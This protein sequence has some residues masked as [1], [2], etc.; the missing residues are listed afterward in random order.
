MAG[1]PEWFGDS[2]KNT[3]SQFVLI[4]EIVIGATIQAQFGKLRI[5]WNPPRLQDDPMF[6][7]APEILL[8]NENIVPADSEV[9]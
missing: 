9:K 5:G 6:I 2:G 8:A 4:H 7:L 1:V 3:E